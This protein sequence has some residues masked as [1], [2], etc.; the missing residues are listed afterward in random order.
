MTA[1]DTGLLAA[2]IFVAAVIYSAVG[3]AGATGYLAAM[4]LFGMP[5]A[6]MRPTAL[7]LNILVASIGTVR[8]RQAGLVDWKSVL[9]LLL[10]SVPASFIGGSLELSGAWYRLLVSTVLILGAFQ[11][12]S[13]QAAI[14]FQEPP[15]VPW[16]IG[17]LA[18]AGIGLLSGLTGTGGGIFL[19]PLLLA[20]GWAGTRQSFGISAPFNLINSIAALAGN[21]LILR[22]LPPELPYLFIAALLGGI[23]GTQIGLRLASAVALQRLLAATLLVAAVK[24]IVTA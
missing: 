12:L 3:Q 7:T 21:I 16:L 18:G 22:S 20:L 1:V 10:T 6:A 5:P 15:R 4:A 9:P 23:V 13:P 8:W 19:S 17:L 11:M 14:D 2:L 24:L